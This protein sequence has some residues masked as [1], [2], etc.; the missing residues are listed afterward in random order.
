MGYQNGGAQGCAQLRQILGWYLADSSKS[1]AASAGRLRTRR[2]RALGIWH[3]PVLNDIP[4][5]REGVRTTHG[6]HNTREHPV[7]VRAVG[8]HRN[9]ARERGVS[10]NQ[11][12]IDLAIE[13]LDRRAWPGT[14][15][16]IA[17][18]RASLFAA[19]A[20]A[21]DL[22]ADGRNKDVQEI[23]EFISTVVPDPNGE[24]ER[25]PHA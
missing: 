17:V 20:I 25:D 8:A 1:G 2:P 4:D 6:T 16:E 19:Q 15:T 7:H 23:R 24:P 5:L 11:L 3:D 10:P 9:A 14:T 18:A 22:I 12:V 13:A 21:R